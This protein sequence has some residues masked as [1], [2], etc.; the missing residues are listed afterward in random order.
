MSQRGIIRIPDPLRRGST[1]QTGVFE[2][3]AIKEGDIPL[4]LGIELFECLLISG[5]DRVK[6]RRV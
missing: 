5:L 1:E 4:L 6:A 2:G 3:L